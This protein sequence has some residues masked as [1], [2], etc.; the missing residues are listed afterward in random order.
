MRVMA[1]RP[2]GQHGFNDPAMQTLSATIATPLV[3]LLDPAAARTILGQIEARSGLSPRGTG[4]DRRR[5]VAGG[6]GTFGPEARRG[7]RR[8]RAR[9]ARSE[10]AVRRPTVGL[11]KMT[12]A[13]LTPPDRREEYL[14]EKIG[15]SWRPG[16]SH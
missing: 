3:A 6:L 7:A 9:R 13:L 5:L 8:C 10:E 11:L 12:E 1:A 2:D 14:R 16:F 4:Q 15:A